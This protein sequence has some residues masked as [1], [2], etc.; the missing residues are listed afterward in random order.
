MY[1]SFAY[2][3]SV[4]VY[5]SVYELCE[6]VVSAGGQKSVEFPETVN[7]VT[8]LHGLLGTEARSP[9]ISPAPRD[10]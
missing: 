9:A 2:T 10:K 6:R 7:K 8:N 1:E 4:S 5:V 3:M